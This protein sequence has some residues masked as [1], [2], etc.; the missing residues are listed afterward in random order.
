MWSEP[1]SLDFLQFI[2]MDKALSN[3]LFC[4]TYRDEE[5]YNQHR[6]TIW[7]DAISKER[8]LET[9]LLKDLS[10]EEIQTFLSSAL[11]LEDEEL[12]DLPK[13]LLERTNGNLFYVVQLMESLQDLALVTY[14][15]ARM[16]WTFSV[17]E[18]IK[19]TTISDNVGELVVS[20][21]EQLPLGVQQVLKL[22]SCFHKVISGD[23]LEKC[24]LILYIV[25]DVELCLQEACQHQLLIQTSEKQYKF[26][27]AQVQAAAYK[28]LP[29]G[30][31]RKK[32][33]WEIGTRLLKSRLKN[34]DALFG[35]VDQLKK[36]L[37]YVEDGVRL[38]V[39]EVSLKAGY[40][41]AELSAFVVASRY[42]QMGMDVLG[43]KAFDEYHELAVDLYSSY[44]GRS[45]ELVCACNVAR[46][47]KKAHV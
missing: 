14:D 9:I 8:K 39:A 47:A 25:D 42:F 31:E 38:R 27:H 44:A 36:G 41:A 21:I 37:K 10:F 4:A 28:L 2:L 26:A 32:I 30:S 15:Y 3:V 5:V 1:S 19:E 18:I 12:D 46:L 43:E 24:R 13:V 35:C 34:D 16:K 6:M 33:H 23:L 7:R 45:P 17:E 22:A 20:K 40:R 29:G 11:N